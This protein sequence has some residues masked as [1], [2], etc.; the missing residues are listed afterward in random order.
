MCA[1]G[2]NAGVI[3]Y[4]DHNISDTTLLLL[5][6]TRSGDNITVNTSSS[7]ASGVVTGMVEG[8]NAVIVNGS[9]VYFYTRDAIVKYFLDTG[10]LFISLKS[11]TTGATNYGNIFI[12]DS[13]RILF[14]KG[15]DTTTAYFKKFLLDQDEFIT[16]TNAAYTAGDNVPYANNVFTGFSS[17]ING[18]KYYIN[19]AASGVIDVDTYQLVGK[20]INATTLLKN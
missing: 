7:F 3:A 1:N 15:N 4:T 5:S 10:G 17:L 8:K 19:E 6:F 16:S 9:F 11:Y 12:D 20:A 13:D 14:Y 18:V 2:T